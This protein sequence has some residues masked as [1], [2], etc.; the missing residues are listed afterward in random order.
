[1]FQRKNPYSEPVAVLDPTE[2]V[3]RP[4]VAGWSR[5]KSCDCKGFEASKGDKHICVCG[6]HWLQHW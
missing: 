3:E 4:I 5:C 2:G 6:H 1:M